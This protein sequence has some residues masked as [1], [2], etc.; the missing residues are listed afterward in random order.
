MMQDNSKDLK[1]NFFNRNSNLNFRLNQ[2]EKIDMYFEAFEI[3]NES[4]F[5]LTTTSKKKLQ[6]KYQDRKH[7]VSNLEKIKIT[8]LLDFENALNDII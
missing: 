6:I 7:V 3:F 2:L 1:E 4:I 5:D 8:S